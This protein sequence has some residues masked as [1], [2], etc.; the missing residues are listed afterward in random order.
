VSLR[1]A[2]A[3]AA[4]TAV[5]AGAFAQQT[6][7]R[8]GGFWRLVPGESD[9]ARAKMREAMPPDGRRGFP[10]GH[11]GQPGSGP[12]GG[13]SPGGG[14]MGGSPMGGSP[15]GPPDRGGH[16]GIGDPQALMRE[17]M[18]PPEALTIVQTETEITLEDVDGNT[19]VLHPDGKKWKR[20]GGAI[21]TH[22]AWK[23]TS[24]VVESQTGSMR[25]TTTYDLPSPGRLVVLHR[26]RPPSGSEVEIKRV[27]AAEAPKVS[28]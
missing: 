23:G 20:G 4:L 3:A 8:L 27:F 14:P 17:V 26:L 1:R 25:L 21:E 22:A 6:A 28:P 15:G 16:G 13:G 2:L 7:P 19:V 9:D 11:G 12:P 5:G 18:T 24:L 10:G